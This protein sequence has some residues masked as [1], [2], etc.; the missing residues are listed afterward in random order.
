EYL[1]SLEALPFVLRLPEV[2]P[3]ARAGLDDY[4]VAKGA[5]D[6][7]QLL[8]TKALEFSTAH[9]L[10]QLNHEVLLIR[11]VACIL[12]VKTDLR[13]SHYQFTRVNYANRKYLK[14]TGNTRR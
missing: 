2:E 10:F 9:E 5:D 4:I 13:M 3:G 8:Q 7:F 14:P 12:E 6:F 11:D 1:L